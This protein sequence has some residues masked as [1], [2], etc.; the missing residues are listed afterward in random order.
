MEN[1]L[2]GKIV[3]S[4]LLKHKCRYCSEGY[5]WQS[6]VLKKY[7]K[8]G[9]LNLK[10]NKSDSIYIEQ[11]TN[12]EFGLNLD[13]IKIIKEKGEIMDKRL[14]SIILLF[15][16]LTLNVCLLIKEKSDEKKYL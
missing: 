11:D 3:D 8:K 15:I 6:K 16:V 13:Q 5:C 10:L 4:R 1:T 7:K 12:Q 2:K 9:Y 14:K